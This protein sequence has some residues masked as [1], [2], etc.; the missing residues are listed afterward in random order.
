[1]VLEQETLAVAVVL[2]LEAVATNKK[3]AMVVQA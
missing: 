3:V 2:V 1:V